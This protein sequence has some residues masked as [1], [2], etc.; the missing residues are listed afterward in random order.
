MT[1]L[2]QRQTVIGNL[3]VSLGT[4]LA[5]RGIRKRIQHSASVIG[6]LPLLLRN[7]Y[8][9]S[10]LRFRL[11]TRN[12]PD[13]FYDMVLVFDGPTCA[14]SVIGMLSGTTEAN[15]TSTGNHL[16][17]MFITDDSVQD[18]GFVARYTPG[19]EYQTYKNIHVTFLITNSLFSINFG[20]TDQQILAVV[21]YG[22][23]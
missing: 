15:Y 9:W 13:R 20:K 5:T 11:K 7:E 12:Y 21:A 2:T 1:R 23:K 18:T 19:E 17:V 3:L 8:F 4:D 22:C 14:S 10:F 16:A 6:K